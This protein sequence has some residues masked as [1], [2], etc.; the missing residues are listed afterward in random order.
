MG[1]DGSAPVA[2]GHDIKV[3]FFDVDGTLLSFSTHEEPD[4]SREAVR[5]LREN[6]VLPILCTGRAPYMLD[7][8][9]R[10]HF[11]GTCTFNGALC[12]MSD[13]R[14]L[15]RNPLDRDDVATILHQS[16]E[17]RLYASIYMEEDRLYLTERNE[18][19]DELERMVGEHY[20]VSEDPYRAL[21]HDVFQL[22]IFATSEG[23]RVASD[24]TRNLD[25]TRWTELFCDVIPKGGGKA[26]AVSRVLEL[27]GIDPGEAVAFGD[28]GNDLG[29]F[30]VVG[31]AVA[32]GNAAGEVRAAA[33]VVTDDVDH[34]G[35]FNACRR[36][37]LF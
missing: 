21:D 18:I 30:G 5:R 35:I 9:E 14:E 26:R 31:T 23:Q 6:G 22:N 20:P 33:D 10:D 37:N 19:V 11:A 29:M 34:D 17:E 27:L 16:V 13:G 7:M 1:S 12:A 28:G 24:V 36:L 3:A 8:I 2:R 4:R 25:Y 32:M 15:V